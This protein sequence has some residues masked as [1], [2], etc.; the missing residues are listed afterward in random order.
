LSTLIAPT[1]QLNLQRNAKPESVAKLDGLGEFVS[2][3]TKA[4]RLTQPF[5]E[6]CCIANKRNAADITSG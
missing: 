6:A 3:V 2:Y 1:E 5:Y 4:M